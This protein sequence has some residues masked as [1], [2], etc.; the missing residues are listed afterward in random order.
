MYHT[1]VRR[2]VSICCPVHRGVGCEI[3]RAEVAAGPFS[4]MILIGC[5]AEQISAQEKQ[6]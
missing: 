2:W 4:K 5:S 3:E 1:G 6:M